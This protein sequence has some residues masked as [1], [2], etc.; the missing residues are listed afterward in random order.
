MLQIFMFKFKHV[1]RSTVF[2]TDIIM[3][4]YICKNG[5]NKR[6]RLL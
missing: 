4:M 5:Q 3:Q 6:Y 1:T 2:L